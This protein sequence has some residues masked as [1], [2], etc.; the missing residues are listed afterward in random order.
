[1]NITATVHTNE[2]AA[3]AGKCRMEF[4]RIR[5]PG[6]EV[7][8]IISIAHLEKRLNSLPHRPTN[9]G[10]EGGSRTHDLPITKRRPAS[11][12]KR[13]SNLFNGLTVRHCQSLPAISHRL[14]QV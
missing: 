2:E 1:M 5:E 9:S 3:R 13:L 14:A 8:V 10:A 12:N 7:K 4:L 6:G 11:L